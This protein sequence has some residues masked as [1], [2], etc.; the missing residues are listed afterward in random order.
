MQRVVG[1]GIFAR[2]FVALLLAQK[3]NA[4]CNKRVVRYFRNQEVLLQVY[5]WP[6]N[7]FTDLHCIGEESSMKTYNS[8]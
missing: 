5:L 2:H 1:H 6:A 7:G 4:V 8:T 3:I